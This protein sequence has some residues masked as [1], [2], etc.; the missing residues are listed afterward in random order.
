MNSKLVLFL[1]LFLF[2]CRKEESFPITLEYPRTFELVEIRNTHP[3]WYEYAAAAFL[4]TKVPAT[5]VH[6]PD[7]VAAL[8]APD[9]FVLPFDRV[10]L[11]ADNSARIWR[12]RQGVALPDTVVR[13]RR[14]DRV[15]VTNYYLYYPCDTGQ[16]SLWLEIT[17]Y[18]GEPAITV[19]AYLYEYSY[20]PFAPPFQFVHSPVKKYYLPQGP[21]LLWAHLPFFEEFNDDTDTAGAK[22]IDL[23]YK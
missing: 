17:A 16:D 23:S 15:N 1:C 3:I 5:F 22:R 13:A 11:L 21:Y 20:Q 14:E 7:S 8:M 10:E 19:Y 12:T 6:F 4:E 9:R 18:T 2:A